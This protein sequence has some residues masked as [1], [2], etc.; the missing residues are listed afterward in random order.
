MDHPDASPRSREQGAI[1]ILTALALLV[2]F[3]AL[4][5]TLGRNSLREVANAGTEWQAAKASEAAEAGLDWFIL[6]TD[7]DNLPS[8]TSR[9]RDTLAN[10]FTQMN[11]SGSWQA[12]SSLLLNPANTWD[13]AFAIRSTEQSANSD[14]VFANTGADFLQ[15]AS[16]N[17]TVQSFDLAF[18]YLGDPSVGVISGAAG[19]SGHTAGHT[20]GTTGRNPNLYQVQSTGKASVPIGLNNY[21]RYANQREMVIAIAP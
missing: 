15:A 20:T 2:L 13:R 5:F 17:A 18:R 12:Q 9:D 16:G 1:T 21:I 7:K 19:G 8:A 10:A 4:A 6:W 3:S 11:L 14:M